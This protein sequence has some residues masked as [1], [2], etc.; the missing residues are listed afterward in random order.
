[1]NPCFDDVHPKLS[2][3]VLLE[4]TRE[5]PERGGLLR[6]A[7]DVITFVI[8]IPVCGQ[9]LEKLEFE[10]SYGVFQGSDRSAASDQYQRKTPEEGAKA[11]G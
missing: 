8:T 2:A 10:I 9:C 4:G 6:M 11:R 3:D 5:R 7:P 1:L